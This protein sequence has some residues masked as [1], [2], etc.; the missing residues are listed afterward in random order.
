MARHARTF[1][2]RATRVEAGWEPVCADD[3][4]RET[5]ARVRFELARHHRGKTTAI[6]CAKQVRSGFYTRVAENLESVEIIEPARILDVPFVRQ[7]YRDSLFKF[8]EALERNDR[9][10][11]ETTLESLKTQAPGSRLALFAERGIAL[12][13]NDDLRRLET[14]SA[15]CRCA[16]RACCAISTKI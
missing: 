13:D 1:A 10:A 2:G 15:H 16:Q 14:T 8:R 7:N 11:A 3:G 5:V 9:E 6:A 12:Y 4:H